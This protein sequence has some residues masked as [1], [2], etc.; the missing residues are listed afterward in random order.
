MV[1][2]VD[3]SVL[4]QMGPPDMRI[5]I[6]HAL[7]HPERVPNELRGFD[8]ARFSRLDLAEVDPA[9]FPALELG[10]RCVEI[11]GD[12]GAALNAA[13][14]V[15]VEAFLDGRIGF[16]E[17]T[18]LNRSVLERAPGVGRT[19]PELLEADARAR[20]EAQAEIGRLVPSGASAPGSPSSRA[21]Q[22]SIDTSTRS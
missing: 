6:H 12:A 3:G 17:I 10:Y 20:A 19:V 7:Y 8:P 16:Q 2:F 1:E 4:A 22:G 11:G 18:R 5:P 21:S 15:A 14:E 9:R 13:D